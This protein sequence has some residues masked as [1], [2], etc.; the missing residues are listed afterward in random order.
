MSN[1][2]KIWPVDYAN[3]QKGDV[4]TARKIEHI[5]GFKQDSNA[6]RFAMMQLQSTIERTMEQRGTPV[7]IKSEKNSLRV[8]KDEEASEYNHKRTLQQ[9]VGVMRTH[10]RAQLVDTGNLTKEDK[11]THAQRLAVSGHFAQALTRAREE[12][13]TL[14]HKRKTP[15]LPP[16][17]TT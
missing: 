5:T 1:T 8:L 2:T 3:L 12:I 11:K 17:Q 10:K 16:Q 14:T 7:T 4:I 15:G 6:F 13:P 9:V